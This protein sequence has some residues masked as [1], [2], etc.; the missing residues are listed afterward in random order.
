MVRGVQFQLH[1]GVPPLLRRCLLATQPSTA[2]GILRYDGAVVCFRVMAGV[3]SVFVSSLSLLRL[4]SLV[5]VSQE[6]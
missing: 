3:R 1:H 5:S 6:E 4:S 2:C